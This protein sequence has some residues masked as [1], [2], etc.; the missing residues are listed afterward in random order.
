[1][2]VSASNR[3]LLNNT[4]YKESTAERPWCSLYC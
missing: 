3:R 1:M 2:T 4:K